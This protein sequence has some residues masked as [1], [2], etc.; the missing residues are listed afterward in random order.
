MTHASHPDQ[1]PPAEGKVLRIVAGLHAGASRALADREMI[2][3]GSGDDCDI[4]LADRGVA[5]HHALISVIDGAVQ[6]RALDAPLKLE[7]RLLHP[8][9]PEELP[10][11]QRIGLGEAA[12]AF[13]DVDDPA[14]LALA[15]EGVEFESPS[16]RPGQAITRR[17]P[18]IAAVSVLSLALLAIFVAVVP[19][20]E[21]PVD[22]EG[23]L[24][25]LAEEHR[26]ANARVLRGH[27]DSWVLSGT[28]GDRATRDALREQVESER[29]PARVDLRSGEDLAYSVS[30][31]LRGG[32][33]RIERV[34]YLGNDDVEVSGYFPDEDAF[35]QFAQSRAVVETGV[36][37][38]VPINLATPPPAPDDTPLEEQD[39]IHIVAVVRGENAHVVALDGTRYEVGAQLPGWGQLVAVGEHAQVLRSDGTLQRLTP[40]PPPAA[41][42]DAAPATDAAAPATPPRQ[43]ASDPRVRAAATRQ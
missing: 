19:A 36:N 7:G 30:E 1:A 8:G 9:D 28:I 32:G 18:M 42:E 37:R 22:I 17:L 11:V 2:L 21:Q 33:F 20:K 26:V 41:V 39:P 4:V 25:A 38:V 34:R 24:R 43:V 5:H 23:R 15:P 6:L 16:P 3:V 35:R 40:R 31:I 10:D 13:G 14:W 29:L 12:L 27:G